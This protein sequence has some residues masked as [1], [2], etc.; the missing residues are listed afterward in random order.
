M[1][2]SPPHTV[3]LL[4]SQMVRMP[5]SIRCHFFEL[6][7]D[8]TRSK[9]VIDLQLLAQHGKPTSRYLRLNILPPT[10]RGWRR[11]PCKYSY[12]HQLQ[13]PRTSPSQVDRG[14]NAKAWLP[15]AAAARNPSLSHPLFCLHDAL[16]R[17]SHP[18]VIGLGLCG[19]QQRRMGCMAGCM[20]ID[21]KK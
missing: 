20:R 7:L 5:G 8:E 17:F 1:V 10:A 6:R 16:P 2:P 11:G 18:V 9:S 12:R 3:L 13:I 21:N 14:G 19:L 15:R 4:Q